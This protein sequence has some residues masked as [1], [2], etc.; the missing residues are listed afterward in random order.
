MIGDLSATVSFAGLVAGL[1]QI[2]E[3]DVQIP[4]G[5]ADGEYSVVVEIGGVSS[6]RGSDCCYI[7]VQ[8]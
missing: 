5:L 6:P 2:Y 8:R 1:P 3:L 7:T 4:D